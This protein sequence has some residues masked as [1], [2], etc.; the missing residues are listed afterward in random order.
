MSRAEFEEVAG[1]ALDLIPADLLDRISNVAIV[2]ED[3]PPAD[4]PNLLGL[5]QGIPLPER[6]DSYGYGSLPDKITL[7]QG[8]LQRFSHSTEELK[9]QIAVTVVH[10]IGHYFGIDDDRLHELGWG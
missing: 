10:E 5:Y 6:L 3:D 4:Q 8:S 9:Q 2:I 1:E 7:F